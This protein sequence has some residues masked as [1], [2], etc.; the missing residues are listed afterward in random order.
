MKNREK[1]SIDPPLCLGEIDFFLQ[2]EMALKV[3]DVVFRRSEL[4]TAECP[5]DAVLRKISEYL[6]KQ[7]GW[8]EQRVDAEIHEVKE[9][10]S[11]N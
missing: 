2:E 3:A 9:H 5:S 4:A 1:V 11:W 8:T 7:L 6:G 10:F